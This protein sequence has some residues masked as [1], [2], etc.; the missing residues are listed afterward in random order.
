M[1]IQFNGLDNFRL[2]LLLGCQPQVVADRQR[3]QKSDASTTGSD[4]VLQVEESPRPDRMTLPDRV[5]VPAES[6]FSFVLGMR[7]TTEIGNGSRRGSQ[8]NG[9][10][11]FW[12]TVTQTNHVGGRGI[13]P[14]SSSLPGMPQI[15]LRPWFN[16]SNRFPMPCEFSR[17]AGTRPRWP[18]SAQASQT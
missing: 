16:P 7:E 13:S 5:P 12:A 4:M 15:R 18:A 2:P 14:A 6:K 9:R 17:P 11:S 8:T 10:S 1:K 3:Q